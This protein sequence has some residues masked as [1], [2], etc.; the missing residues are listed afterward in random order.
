M[1][2]ITKV[3]RK[4][5]RRKPRRELHE[6]IGLGLSPG[7]TT[8][9]IRSISYEI[10]NYSSQEAFIIIEGKAA[11]AEGFHTFCL[12]GTLRVIRSNCWYNGYGYS[13]FEN[14]M[15][16]KLD[17]PI[18]VALDYIKLY[19]VLSD[20]KIPWKKIRHL[21]WT[22][23]KWYGKYLTPSNADQWVAAVERAG[24]E[25]QPDFSVTEMMI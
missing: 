8:D 18:S 19:E 22:Q 2:A 7:N 1:N 5:V 3:Q 23:I 15:M 14:M 25:Y 21:R 16:E 4:K 20:E 11:K 6:H 13:S 24:E 17:L 10:E 9:F 12:G